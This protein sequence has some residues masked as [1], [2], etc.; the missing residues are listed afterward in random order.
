M[1]AWSAWPASEAHAVARIHC[2]LSREIADLVAQCASSFGIAARLFLAE[3]EFRLRLD[4]L[5]RDLFV[6]RE[7]WL[8]ASSD[9]FLPDE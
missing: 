7:F 6:L 8:A 4:W 1:C 9:R 3:G 2:A 5:P